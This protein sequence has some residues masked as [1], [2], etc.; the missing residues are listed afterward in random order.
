MTSKLELI[1]REMAD[2]YMATFPGVTRQ[3][4]KR[5]VHQRA[6]MRLVMIQLNTSVAIFGRHYKQAMRELMQAFAKVNL[7][8]YVQ[9]PPEKA[10]PFVRAPGRRVR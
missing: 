9:H 7:N 3:E 4:A 6:E 10:S 1:K 8:T 2:E 5:K